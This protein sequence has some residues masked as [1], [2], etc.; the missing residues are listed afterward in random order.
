MILLLRLILKINL[1]S[2][3]SDRRMNS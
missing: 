1:V 3:F 2:I